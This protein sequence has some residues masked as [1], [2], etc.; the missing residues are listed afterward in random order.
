MK[1]FTIFFLALV[2]PL[3]SS[4]QNTLSSQD[5]DKLKDDVK[6]LQKKD[7][8]IVWQLNQFVKSEKMEI[9]ELKSKLQDQTEQ[10]KMLGDS[11]QQLHSKLEEC[12]LH[13]NSVEERMLGLKSMFLIVF[14]LFLFLLVVLFGFLW[15]KL[16]AKKRFIS[17]LENKVFNEIDQIKS[18]FENQLSHHKMEMEAKMDLY[19]KP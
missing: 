8:N 7:K 14:L 15:L 13:I 12:N 5:V 4:S 3:L 18:G 16:L 17:L 10:C 19:H 9:D 11:L 2:L 1:T 6:A